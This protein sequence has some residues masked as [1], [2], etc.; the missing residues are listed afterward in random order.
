MQWRGRAICVN[1]LVQ[2]RRSAEVDTQLTK[3]IVDICCCAYAEK[4]LCSVN[5]E[6]ECENACL[7]KTLLNASQ[8][9]PIELYEQSVVSLLVVVQH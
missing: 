4:T 9:T 3:S 5:T 6:A 7:R 8:V 2:Q 1:S